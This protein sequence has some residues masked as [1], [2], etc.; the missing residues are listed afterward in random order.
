[1]PLLSLLE[2]DHLD[3]MLRQRGYYLSTQGLGPTG[4]AIKS[5]LLAAWRQHFVQD[6]GMAIEIDTS[7]IT[8]ACKHE[9]HV[10]WTVNDS[11]T[12]TTY[13]ADTLLEAACETALAHASQSYTSEQCARWTLAT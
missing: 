9:E 13:R 4:C 8:S 3:E 2:R 6:T 1:M 11:Q 12:G 5:H 7:S 10:I